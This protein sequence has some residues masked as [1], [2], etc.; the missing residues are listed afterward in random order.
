MIKTNYKKIKSI[1]FIIF[2]ILSIFLVFFSEIIGFNQ[3]NL[4]LLIQKYSF[5]AS[6]IFTILITIA[7]ATTLPIS[8]V[9]V[10][11]FLTFS[12]TETILLTILGTYIGAS[13]IY[14]LARKTGSDFIKNYGD[15]KGQKLKALHQL[16]KNN[17]EKLTIIITLLYFTPSNIAGMIAGATKMK[18]SKFS[19]IN[20]LCNLPGTF[21][22]T[23]IY[24]GITLN[25]PTYFIYAVIIM[26]LTTAIPLL[27][28][29]KHLKEIFVII[30][31]KN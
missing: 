14:F 6:I 7:S 29:K 11:G 13:I 4:N 2:V 30:F 3:A 31:N 17:P 16:I 5:M 28:Y 20:T 1:F 21:L 18:F 10:L 26:T 23:F 25:N 24:F 19:I 9:L 12:P 27:V 15:I 22:I 8:L